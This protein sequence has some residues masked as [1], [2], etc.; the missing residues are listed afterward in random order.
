MGGP[1]PPLLLSSFLGGVFLRGPLRNTGAV[2][3]EPRPCVLLRRPRLSGRPP[4][5]L[6]SHDNAGQRHAGRPRRVREACAAGAALRRPAGGRV[7]SAGVNL[8]KGCRYPSVAVWGIWT[9]K[10]RRYRPGEEGLGHRAAGRIQE[11]RFS[12]PLIVMMFNGGC[13]CGARGRF[14][15]TTLPGKPTAKGPPQSSRAGLARAYGA[16]ERRSMSLRGHNTACAR[17]AIF[18][19]G[20]YEEG[21]GNTVATLALRPQPTRALRWRPRFRQ[22]WDYACSAGRFFLRLRKK[23]LFLWRRASSAARK[24]P[25]FSKENSAASS[26]PPP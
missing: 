2:A 17:Y 24:R 9:A 7:G 13:R 22:K 20:H 26:T 14:R 11:E 4:L 15:T 5:T 6:R 3:S 1:P 10:I 19:A 8:W 16:V 25:C 12:V 23:P 21:A 18:G